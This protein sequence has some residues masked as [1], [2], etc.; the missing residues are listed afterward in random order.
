MLSDTLPA[1][2]SLLP[3]N[4]AGLPDAPGALSAQSRVNRFMQPWCA[5]RVNPPVLPR[6]MAEWVDLRAKL[7]PWRPSGV[8]RKFGPS[9]LLSAR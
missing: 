1:G 2:S 3:S 7:A 6:T 4:Q 5:L 9:N 8:P